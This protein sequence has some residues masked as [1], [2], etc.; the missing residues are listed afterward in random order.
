MSEPI[1]RSLRSALAWAG[2]HRPVAM[3]VVVI[4]LATCWIAWTGWQQRCYQQT[5]LEGRKAVSSR[6]YARALSILRPLPESMTARDEV[7]FLLGTAAHATG[8][9][10]EAIE[11][12]GRV[13]HHSKFAARAVVYRAR[14]GTSARPPFGGR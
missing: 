9:A 2:H 5:L 10:E 7:D 8:R 12:W 14:L 11:S 3:L 1:A 13:P 6:L 4:A